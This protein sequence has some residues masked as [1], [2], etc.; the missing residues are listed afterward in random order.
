M[1]CGRQMYAWGRMP[2][3][4]CNVSVTGPAQS[5]GVEIAALGR[6]GAKSMQYV[7]LASDY[8]GTLAHDGS[9]EAG[10]IAALE[11]LRASGRKLVLVTGREI[12]DLVRVFPSVALFDL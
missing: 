9:V 2:R 1:S 8:D 7:A 10:T 11:R 4:R 12:D 6:S 3:N 5:T